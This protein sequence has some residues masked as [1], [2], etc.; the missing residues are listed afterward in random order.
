MF[1]Y[2]T[3]PIRKPTHQTTT[4]PALTSTYPLCTRPVSHPP[5]ALAGAG[6]FPCPV[7][8]PVHPASRSPSHPRSPPAYPGVNQKPAALR[9]L[10]PRSPA[11]RP[12]SC[13]PFSS[14][15]RSPA[16]LAPPEQPAH[17]APGAGPPGPA[18]LPHTLPAGERPPDPPAV[19]PEQHHQGESPRLPIAAKRPAPRLPAPARAALAATVSFQFITPAPLRSPPHPRCPASRRPSTRPAS[20]APAGAWPVLSRA[21]ALTG[22]EPLLPPRA[23]HPPALA[24]C[25]YLAPARAFAGAP[26]HSP[27]I[28]PRAP[29][30][31][32]PGTPSPPPDLISL[33]NDFTMQSQHPAITPSS[34][35]PLRWAS[36]HLSR[37]AR[38]DPTPWPPRRQGRTTARAFAGLPSAPARSPRRPCPPLR[39]PYP[40]GKP[41]NPP[42]SPPPAPSG[43]GEQYPPPVFASSPRQPA[44][45]GQPT[46]LFR[47]SRSPSLRSPPSYLGGKPPPPPT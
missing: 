45:P 36:A 11:L 30:C 39:S 34:T 18:R 28:W 12:C 31:R 27:T 37:P 32:L 25:L 33:C 42:A 9:S 10:H 35:P 40:S 21:L 16:H 19:P 4:T 7:G 14:C 2:I 43:R 3:P 5:P 15:P 46:A 38:D 41:P 47:I 20:R 6:S 29:A 17:L 23:P 24:S 44:H 26:L 8:L 22:P 13:T 1:W